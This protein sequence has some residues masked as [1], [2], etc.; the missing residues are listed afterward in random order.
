M[1]DQFLE[2]FKTQFPDADPMIIPLL[3][4]MIDTETW[5]FPEAFH[6]YSPI[7]PHV[8]FIEQHKGL[9]E[10]MKNVHDTKK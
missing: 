7:A 6:H 3:I 8:E 2:D 5:R 9:M 10:L 1:I 4:L